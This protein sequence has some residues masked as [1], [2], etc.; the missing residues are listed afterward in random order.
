MDISHDF[1]WQ[2]TN[3]GMRLAFVSN[4]RQH[5]EVTHLVLPKAFHLVY[6]SQ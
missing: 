2:M 1:G 5:Q 4:A 6:L 3:I